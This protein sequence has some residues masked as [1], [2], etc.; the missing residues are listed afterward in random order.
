MLP[1]AIIK[2]TLIITNNMPMARRRVSSSLNISMAIATAVTGST[3]PSIATGVL[4]IFC[5]A[6]LVQ[7]RDT[8]VGNK[9][10]QKADSHSNGSAQSMAN[11]PIWKRK[12][13]RNKPK[14]IT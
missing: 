12:A 10:I 11:V 13:N 8:A 2:V 14:M 7:I 5:M 9:A 1:P 3:A 6:A 4:P